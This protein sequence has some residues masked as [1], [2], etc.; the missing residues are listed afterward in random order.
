MD[1]YKWSTQQEQ[2]DVLFLFFFQ[3]ERK[4]LPR[5]D[6][7]GHYTSLNMFNQI[8]TAHSIFSDYKRIRIT[9][10]KHLKTHK[11]FKTM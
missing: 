5:Y 11:I 7:M 4:Q 8:Q 9:N 2:I 1:F 10:R 3:A 6:V